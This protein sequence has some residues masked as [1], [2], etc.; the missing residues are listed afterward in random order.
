VRCSV[1]LHWHRSYS[2][3][4]LI[5]NSSSNV[6]RSTP[7]SVLFFTKVKA[8]SCSSAGGLRRGTRS[9]RRTSAS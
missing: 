9:W 7:G 1:R 2:C 4:R 3:R 8:L 5:R 6:M